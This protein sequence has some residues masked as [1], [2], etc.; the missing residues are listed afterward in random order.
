ME[1]ERVDYFL[2]RINY[3]K[4]LGRI[5]HYWGIKNLLLAQPAEN[6]RYSVEKG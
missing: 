4:I 6:A 3:N 1:S 5:H 2:H